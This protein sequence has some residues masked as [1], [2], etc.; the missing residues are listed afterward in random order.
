MIVTCKDYY[1]YSTNKTALT[2]KP[3]NPKLP[4]TPLSSWSLSYIYIYVFTLERTTNRS[5]FSA[6]S[7]PTEVVSSGCARGAA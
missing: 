7:F 4:A 6:G 3:L 2:P 1:H 5:Y